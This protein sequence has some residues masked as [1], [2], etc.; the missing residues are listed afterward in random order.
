METTLDCFEWVLTWE[1]QILGLQSQDLIPAEDT[2]SPFSAAILETLIVEKMR[3]QKRAP[4][5][6]GQGGGSQSRN[7]AGDTCDRTDN[8]LN[9]RV[10][11][12]GILIEFKLKQ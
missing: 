10:R 2:A 11:V 4:E 8:E 1:G 3:A 9:G 5:C 7:F 6:V 12:E